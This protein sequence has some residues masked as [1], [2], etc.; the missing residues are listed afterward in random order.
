MTTPSEPLLLHERDA[1]GVH[2]L[3]LNAPR[4]FNALS[5]SMLDALQGALDR[6]VGQAVV[7]ALAAGQRQQRHGDEERGQERMGH[8]Q[9]NSAH[10]TPCAPSGRIPDHGENADQAAARPARRC[11]MRHRRDAGA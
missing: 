1:R 9:R 7:G 8:V 2:R 11:G 4:S 3:T 10:R 6:G 5:S